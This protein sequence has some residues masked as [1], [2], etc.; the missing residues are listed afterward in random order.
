M[1]DP[2]LESNLGSNGSGSCNDRADDG[3]SDG[4]VGEGRHGVSDQKSPTAQRRWKEGVVQREG[5]ELR[6]STSN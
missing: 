1:C 5:E 4:D 6:R 2:L 3:K